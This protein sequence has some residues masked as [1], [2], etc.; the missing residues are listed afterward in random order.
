TMQLEGH[1]E[2]EGLHRSG[3]VLSLDVSVSALYLGDRPQ[4]MIILRD[5]SERKK[6]E[7]RLNFFA[8]H[9][10]LTGLYNRHH[11]EMELNKLLDK[12]C[13]GWLVFLDLDDFKL[14]NDALGHQAGDAA[15]VAMSKRLLSAL[16]ESALVSRFSGDEFVIFVP[17]DSDLGEDDLLEKLNQLLHQPVSSSGMEF[18]LSGSLGVVRVPEHGETVQALLRNA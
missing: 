10:A 9:D 11:F 6:Q 14:I 16:G 7:A 13:Q 18:M 8:E 4:R 3:M 15:L 2:L 17:A 1:Y 5:V 12:D